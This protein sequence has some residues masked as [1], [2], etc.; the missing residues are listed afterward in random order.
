M[1]TVTLRVPQPFNE[2][3]QYDEEGELIPTSWPS[4]LPHEDI[5]VWRILG[6][7]NGG[8]DLCELL[9]DDDWPVGDIPGGWRATSS[10]AWDGV[11]QDAYD[12]EGNFVRSGLITEGATDK[13]DYTLHIPPPVDENGDPTGEPATYHRIHKYQGWPDIID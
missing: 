6:E 7:A 9:C 3:P 2:G 13:D 12:E 11:R 5:H 10:H 1:K 4:G 8:L